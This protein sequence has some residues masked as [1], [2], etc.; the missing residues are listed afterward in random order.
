MGILTNRSEPDPGIMFYIDDNRY[1]H[2]L[3]YN[4]ETHQDQQVPGEEIEALFSTPIQLKTPRLRLIFPHLVM[5]RNMSP[6]D[7]DTSN[8]VTGLDILGAIY[9]YYSLPV[10]SEDLKDIPPERTYEVD[11]MIDEE[12]NWDPDFYED[13]P[14]PE[15][16]PSHRQYNALGDIQSALILGRPPSRAQALIQLEG[17][18]SRPYF[19]DITANLDGS[20]R[21]SIET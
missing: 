20:Y 3:I 4:P 18:I 6:V 16:M 14:E 21:I 12:G 8:V 7:F 15:D 17:G 13:N 1:D 19:S 2:I 9:T 10:T 11:E 5:S